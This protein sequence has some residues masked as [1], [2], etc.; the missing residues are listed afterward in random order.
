MA[1]LY[2]CKN[3]RSF[4]ALWALEEIGLPYELKLLPFPPRVLAPEYLQINPLGTIPLLID[5]NV[6]MTK[7]AA[8]CQYLADR[9]S[10]SVLA[11]ES[12]RARL[13]RVPKCP[14]LW[15]S[16]ADFSSDNC[17]ALRLP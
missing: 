9:Y 1:T 2:H 11:V 15:R 16:D 14:S 10:K 8:I 17:L 4:R 7:S 3:A 12:S 5:G 6:K 13:W